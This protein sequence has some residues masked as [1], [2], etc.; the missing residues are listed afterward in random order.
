MDSERIFGLA[1]GTIVFS[2]PKLTDAD[3]Y[4]GVYHVRFVRGCIALDVAISSQMAF[5]HLWIVV[6]C[7]RLEN[8]Q[9]KQTVSQ[10]CIVVHIIT[11][12]YL[13]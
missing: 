13:P 11:C 5:P 4:A 10:Q 3:H 12:T 8:L 9:R 1:A 7:E 6:T 2:L